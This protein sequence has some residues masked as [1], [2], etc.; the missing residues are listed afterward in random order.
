[1]AKL[2]K[3]LSSN[4][5]Q[6][7]WQSLKNCLNNNYCTIQVGKALKDWPRK[8]HNCNSSQVDDN[9]YWLRG[10]NTYVNEIFLYF[11]LYFISNI[12]TKMSKNIFSLWGVVCREKRTYWSILNS[13]CNTTKCGTS[14]GVGILSEGTV[15]IDKHY[16]QVFTKYS[17]PF[18]FSTCSYVR[19]LF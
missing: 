17:D 16:L 9:I 7:F 2:E 14:Q 5:Q 4:D 19:A 13:G 15:H 8:T 6:S 10:V 1:M 18:P 12:F 3:W 11:F